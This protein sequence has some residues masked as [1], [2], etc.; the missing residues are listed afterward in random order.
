MALTKLASR[1]YAWIILKLA[2]SCL[3][4]LF[5]NIDGWY[6][7]R[8]IRTPKL[9]SFTLCLC[10]SY[11]IIIIIHIFINWLILTDSQSVLQR[12]LNVCRFSY[13]VMRIIPGMTSLD[14]Q[15]LY[16]RL[17]QDSHKFSTCL[18]RL[19]LYWQFG[20]YQCC[21]TLN[22][23]RLARTPGEFRRWCGPSSKSIWKKLQVYKP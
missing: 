8:C 11:I 18:T 1:R 21:S 17:K 20:K 15:F 3:L 19:Q 2:E 12:S 5:M 6:I 13:D 4:V 10:L 7:R 16:Y 9:I 14:C 23:P 22:M